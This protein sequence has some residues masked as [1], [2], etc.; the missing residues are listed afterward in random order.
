MRQVAYKMGLL[1]NTLSRTIQ[2]L[3]GRNMFNKDTRLKKVENMK[4]KY[5]KK[6]KKNNVWWWEKKVRNECIIC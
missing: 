3:R 6:E 5:N 4:N 2:S 1:R